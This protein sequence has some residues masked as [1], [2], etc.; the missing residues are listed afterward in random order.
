MLVRKDA[1]GINFVVALSSQERGELL[2]LGVRNG[3]MSDEALSLAIEVGLSYM[4]CVEQDLRDCKIEL[5]DDYRQTV[6]NEL[7]EGV[8]A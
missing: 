8:A 3:L 1:T 5:H 7:A 2:S 6:R 4:K